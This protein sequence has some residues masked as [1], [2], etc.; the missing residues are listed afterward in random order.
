MALQD[1]EADG[2]RRI[3][4][5]GILQQNHISQRLAHLLAANRDEVVVDPILYEGLA[6]RAFTLRNLAFMM[7]ELIVHSAA[8]DIKRFAE[9][10]H[11][12]CRAFD[13]PA[14]KTD[15]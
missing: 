9:I 1:K 13:M 6:C 4:F 7:R 12:H 3:F 2:K 10:F 8:V 14:G 11:R 15:S 5:E